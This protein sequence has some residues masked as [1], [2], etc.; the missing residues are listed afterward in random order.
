MPRK[1]ETLTLSIPPGVREQLD[2]LAAR[3]GY[4][5][6]KSPSPSALVTAIAQGDLTLSAPLAL[7]GSQIAALQQA[8]KDLVDAGHVDEAKNVITLLIDQAELSG[9]LRQDLMRQVSQ[10]IEGWRLQL[11]QFIRDRQPFHLVYGKPN[12]EPVEFTVCYAEIVPLEKRLYLQ[13][14]CEETADNRDVSALAHN[15]TLRLD[16]IQGLVPIS[17]GW[18]GQFDDILVELHFLRGLVYAYE[19]RPKDVEDQTVDGVRRVMRQIHNTF[20][21]FREV[22][23]YGADCIVIGPPEV[24]DRFAQEIAA[25]YQHYRPDSP[26]D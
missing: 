6:G 9:P 16:R 25:M 17:G 3:F 4:R 1:K 14:W 23:R 20:W 22:R 8:V 2:Q 5:W 18:Q 10:S 7:T 24:R 21:F 12:R 19:P 11:D 13:I 26:G 15:R